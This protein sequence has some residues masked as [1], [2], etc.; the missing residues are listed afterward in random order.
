MKQITITNGE[1]LDRTVTYYLRPL[2]PGYIY[3]PLDIIYD[4]DTLDL[5]SH[6]ITY[7]TDTGVY[8]G[9]TLDEVYASEKYN[10]ADKLAELGVLDRASNEYIDGYCIGQNY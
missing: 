4:E 5:V 1:N 3:N 7:K 9:L 6:K 10:V 8:P 2:D